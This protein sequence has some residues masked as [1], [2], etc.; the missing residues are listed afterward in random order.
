M[1]IPAYF[2]YIAK[3]H[4]KIIKKLHYLSKVNN[5][6][7][8]CNSIIYDAIRELEKENK[9]LTEQM[10]FELICKKVEQ[11]IYLVKPTNV[12]YI[13]FDGVAPVAKLEQQRTRRYKSSFEDRVIFLCVSFINYLCH[14]LPPFFIRFLPST[15]EIFP[16]LR[17]LR[18]IPS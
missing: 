1:G 4:V 18:G 9:D 10:I 17:G 5:L 11:Y 2:A 13:A 16:I 6:L 7:F 3:N 14:H 15:I 12:I 8:D